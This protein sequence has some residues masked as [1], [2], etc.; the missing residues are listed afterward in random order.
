M[1]LREDIRGAEIQARKERDALRLNVLRML[2]SAVRNEE[3]RLQRELGDFE[4]IGLAARQ[5]KQ[6]EDARADF[7]RGNRADLIQQT[8]QE[9]AILRAFLPAQ[10]P[11]EELRGIVKEIV[12]K[13]GPDKAK[14]GQIMGAVM[15]EVKSRA[16]GNRVR[17]SVEKELQ[18]H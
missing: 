11:D 8:E 16:D 9:V 6:L 15:K 18:S 7:V 2:W 17:E 3:I 4:I 10:M 1:S 5:V 13:A 14:I 12:S